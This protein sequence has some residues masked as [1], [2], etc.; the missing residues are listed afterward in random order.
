MKKDKQK[1]NIVRILTMTSI[2]LLV[3]A[4]SFMIST[5]Y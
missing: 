2:G 4:I 3:L 1:I 5:L